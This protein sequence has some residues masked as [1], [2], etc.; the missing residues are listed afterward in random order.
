MTPELWTAVAIAVLGAI[1]ALGALTLGFIN[2]NAIHGVHVDVNSRLTQLVQANSRAEHAEGLALG[3][4]S[5]EQIRAMIDS[6]IAKAILT[7]P[8]GP[9]ESTP[10][11]AEAIVLSKD[12][13]VRLQSIQAEANAVAAALIIKSAATAAAALIKEQADQAAAAKDSPPS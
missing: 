5:A 8:P 12:T 3:G 2:R 6:A 11:L 7:P 13:N 1:P 4:A 9:T 10:G